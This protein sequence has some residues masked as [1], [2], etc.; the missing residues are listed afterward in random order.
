MREIKF[1]GIVQEDTAEN[2][3]WASGNLRLPIIDGGDT[4]IQDFCSGLWY[5]VNPK[6]IGQST[7]LKDKKGV[8]IYEGDILLLTGHETVTYIRIIASSKRTN[9]LGWEDA[10]Y[11]F[12]KYHCEEIFEIIGNIHDNPELLEADN[13]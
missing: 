3:S 12:C 7:G 1:R 10:G 6:T 13:V 4:M 9:Q 11:C 2:G 5:V 8:E